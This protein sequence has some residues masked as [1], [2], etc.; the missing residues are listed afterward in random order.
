MLTAVGRAV[1]CRQKKKQGSYSMAD[2]GFPIRRGEMGLGVPTPE[3]GAKAYYIF[4]RKLHENERNCIERG[5]Y[6][7]RASPV[8]GSANVISEGTHSYQA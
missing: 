8:L 5:R 3:F 6:L 1:T 4:C 2:P 7:G